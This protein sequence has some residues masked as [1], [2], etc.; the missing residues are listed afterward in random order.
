MEAWPSSSW[1]CFPYGTA[2]ARSNGGTVGSDPNCID[3]PLWRSTIG[4]PNAESTNMA[5]TL[6]PSAQN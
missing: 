3:S 6:R 4:A 5:E 1:I 2:E